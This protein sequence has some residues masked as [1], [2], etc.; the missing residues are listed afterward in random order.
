MIG[1]EEEINP[2]WEE[3]VKRRAFDSRVKYIHG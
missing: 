2:A 1:T 3:L